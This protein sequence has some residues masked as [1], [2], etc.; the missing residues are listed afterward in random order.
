[1]LTVVVAEGYSEMMWDTGVFLLHHHHAQMFSLIFFELN[2]PFA[3]LQEYLE[4]LQRG[5][6][7]ALPFADYPQAMGTAVIKLLHSS[8]IGSW[9]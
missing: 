5:C 2:L 1:M 9:R 4:A 8:A 7:S 3:R 6:R